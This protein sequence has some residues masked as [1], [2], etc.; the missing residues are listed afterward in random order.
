M[1]VISILKKP[2]L[3]RNLS[4]PRFL[5]DYRF[6]PMIRKKERERERESRFPR[7]IVRQTETKH[8]TSK[9]VD[10]TIQVNLLQLGKGGNHPFEIHFPS[11]TSG[12]TR[13]KVDTSG[14]IMELL[15]KYKNFTRFQAGSTDERTCEYRIHWRTWPNSSSKTRVTRDPSF[16]I[17]TTMRVE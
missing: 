16:V 10:R 17:F 5:E 12:Q 11:Q 8:S 1:R 13:P 9:L 6:L 2:L 7:L 14:L 15:G 4:R 3:K